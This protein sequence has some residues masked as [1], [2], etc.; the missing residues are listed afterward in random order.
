MSIK[1]IEAELDRLYVE[2]QGMKSEEEQVFF[3]ERIIPL[4]RKHREYLRN[5]GGIPQGVFED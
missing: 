4:I 1:E 2:A 5:H 3:D